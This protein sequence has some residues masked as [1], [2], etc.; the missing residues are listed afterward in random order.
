MRI[1]LQRVSQ[2]KV[3]VDGRVVGSIGQ[4][5]MAL[6]GVGRTDDD[7][8]ARALAEKVVT[9]RIFEDE[10]GK[11]NLSLLDVGGAVLVVSQFTL[12]ADCRKGRRPSFA[13][14]GDPEMAAR[15]VEVLRNTVEEFGVETASG[16]FGA[17]M[18]V[19][20]VN[21]GPFTIVLDEND[22]AVGRASIGPRRGTTAGEG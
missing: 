13:G 12:Y 5:L 10:D 9:L 1:V 11:T 18:Q 3:E 6:V 22:V 14:A 16:V 20:L 2:A 7:S 8:L 19:S 15:L 17:H 4:G 21:D